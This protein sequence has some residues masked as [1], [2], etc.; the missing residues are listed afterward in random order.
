MR[1]IHCRL[2][3]GSWCEKRKR[4]GK[5]KRKSKKVLRKHAHLWIHLGRLCKWQR[6]HICGERDGVT[7]VKQ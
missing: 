3:S 2:R 6:L 4:R 1:K 7:H 5:H